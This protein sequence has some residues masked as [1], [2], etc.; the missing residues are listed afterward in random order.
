MKVVGF[1]SSPRRD[2]NTSIL[3]GAVF[4]ELA[5]AGI[6]TQLI[7][8]GIRPVQGCIACGKCAQNR[9]GHCAMHTDQVNDWLAIMDQADGIILGS[10]VYIA[11]V[12]GQMKNFIDRTAMTARANGDMFARKVGAGVV[13]VRRA[14]A[15][16]AFHSL[17]AWFAICQMVVVG[18]GYWNMGFG[19][20]PGE[21]NRDPEGLQTMRN[22]GRNMAW[23]L[24]SI[25]AGCDRVAVPHT[26]AEVMTNFVRD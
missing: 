9:D 7:N 26:P 14:G 22:L 3:L 15:L 8:I 19:L 11:D 1:N 4:A 2:G 13:A 12:N 17:N 16:P 24:H 21:V 20:H 23:L 5:Q 10:P 6:T 18:A 25:A